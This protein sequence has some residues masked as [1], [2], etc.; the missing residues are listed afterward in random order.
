MTQEPFDFFQDHS[1][2]FLEMAFKSDR[3]EPLADP[4]GIGRH[5]GDCGDTVEMSLKLEGRT[6]NRVAFQVQ[7]CMNTVASANA[8]AELIEGQ[9]IDTAWELTPEKVIDFLETLPK[10]HHHCAELAV[11]ALYRAL[12]DARSKQQQPWRKMYDKG[13][14]PHQNFK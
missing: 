3:L 8:V 14:A 7:G 12:A 13:G 10:G 4:D 6:I 9:S 2:K 11:G 5:T 1:L